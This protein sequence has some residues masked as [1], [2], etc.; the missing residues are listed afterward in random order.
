M[1]LKG[2]QAR[3][4]LAVMSV[5]LTERVSIKANLKCASFKSLT[6]FAGLGLSFFYNSL[7]TGVKK[8]IE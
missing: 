3:G 1:K 5:Q 6:T 2:G 8:A 4:F 7:Y